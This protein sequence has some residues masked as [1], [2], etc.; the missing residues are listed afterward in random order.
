MARQ[1]NRVGLNAATLEAPS[2]FNDSP[3]SLERG[4]VSF[5]PIFCA[6]PRRR[7]S[8]SRKC[9]PLPDGCWASRLPG[10]GTF[11]H[12]PGRLGGRPDA[13]HD[14]RL[15]LR[16]FDGASGAHGPPGGGGG[17]LPEHPARLQGRRRSTDPE[18]N[19]TTNRP[20]IPRENILLIEAV[21]DWFVPNETTEELWR[22]WVQPDI[23]RLRHGHISVLAAP[24][25]TARIIDWMTPRLR[26]P[27]RK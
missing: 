11:G 14:A 7:G 20:A 26:A 8:P 19:L 22:A 24:G 17:F 3:A 12:L 18:I 21:H 6:R 27:A 4:A 1:F 15:G 13:C 9:G 2:T 5:V 23:W 16:R 10:G 25:L